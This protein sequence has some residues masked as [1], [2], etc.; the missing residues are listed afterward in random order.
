MGRELNPSIGSFDIKTFNE[1]RPG[2][3]LWMLLDISCACEQW[4]RLGGRITPSMALVVA[5]H[6]IYV[7]DALYNEVST[8]A[9]SSSTARLSCPDEHPCLPLSAQSAIFT[10]MDVT[11][12]GFGYMLSFGD[13]AWVPFTYSLQARYLAFHPTELSLPTLGAIVAMEAAGYYIFRTSNGEKNEFRLG[14]NPKSES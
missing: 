2:L 3:I 12:D 11:T 14:N 1:L 6:S 9:I 13:L 4:C 8:F 10:T 7:V 5:F